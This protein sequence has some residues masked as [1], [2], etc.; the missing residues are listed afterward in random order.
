MS[1]SKPTSSTPSRGK[2]SRS[3][4]K[5]PTDRV[6]AAL[7]R[8]SQDTRALIK[9]IDNLAESNRALADSVYEEPESAPGQE[10]QY[11]S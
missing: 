3:G 1:G 9:A 6:L 10:P 4:A 8:Q 5:S 2:R 11:L 7:L